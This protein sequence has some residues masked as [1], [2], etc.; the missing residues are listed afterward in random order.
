MKKIVRLTETDLKRIVKKVIKEEFPNSLIG[1]GDFPR[2]T[3][4]VAK[5]WYK[6]SGNSFFMDFIQSYPNRMSFEDALM[7]DYMEFEDEDG[8]FEDSWDP[9]TEE[10]MLQ[11]EFP[12]YPGSEYW[13]DFYNDLTNA[14]W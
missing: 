12:N 9:E 3:Y 10:Y 8:S 6:L 4:A 7:S 2:M 1:G 5:K 11:Q 13:A 14:G